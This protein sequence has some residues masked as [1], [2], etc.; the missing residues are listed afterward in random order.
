MPTDSPKPNPSGHPGGEFRYL[1]VRARSTALLA[2][3]CLLSMPG[4]VTILQGCLG[5]EKTAADDTQYRMRGDFRK[6]PFESGADVRVSMLDKRGDPSGRNYRTTTENDSGDF[7]L[8]VPGG[9]AEFSC[10]GA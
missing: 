8:T 7:R 3:A 4:P 9:V 10:T 1:R 6:G 2:A 5:T